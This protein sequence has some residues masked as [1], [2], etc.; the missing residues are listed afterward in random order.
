MRKVGTNLQSTLFVAALFHVDQEVL[1]VQAVGHES[2]FLVVAIDTV[3]H[4]R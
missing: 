2:T 1:I 3:D 4:E